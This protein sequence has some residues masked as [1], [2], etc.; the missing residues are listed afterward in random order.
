M[1]K[2]LFF[3]LLLFMSPSI[4][5]SWSNHMYYSQS[6]LSVMPDVTGAE[7][8]K[9]EKLE[10]FLKKE[11]AGISALLKNQDA[12]LKENYSNY[13]PLPE[14]LIFD[15]KNI[16]NI[17]DDFLK[18]IRVNPEI[19][20]GYYIQAIPGREKPGSSRVDIGS[21]SVFKDISWLE[22]NVFLKVSAGDSVAPID[23]VSTASD[24]PDYGHDIHLFE[25][26]NSDFG[27]VYGFGVQPFGDPKLEYSSQAPFHMGYYHESF[28]IFLAGSFLK[29]T[30][31][32]IRV[33]QYMDLAKFAFKTGHP[34]WGW[35]F[36]GWALH[37]TQ[38]MTQPYHA[39]VLPGSG[40]VNMLYKNMSQKRKDEAVQNVSDSHSAIERYVYENIKS[41]YEKNMLDNTIFLSLKDIRDDKKYGKFDKDYIREIVADQSYSIADDLDDAL[42]ESKNIMKFA[43][44]NFSFGDFTPTKESERVDKQI[45]HIMVNFG[46]HTR[47]LVKAVLTN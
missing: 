42:S 29:Q 36:L 22:N 9:V 23:I 5:F 40:T 15:E 4:L 35:R 18:A 24:E 16:K 21:I 10:T 46:A 14:S 13:P 32:E 37:Y 33:Y 20:L 6:A 3:I 1:K 30:Y 43:D 27:K 41:L 19:K 31:P 25:D 26:S 28:I 12:F 11:S 39:K 47:N 7:N 17:K 34:Y 8:V 44:S 45:E 2:Y 38:D